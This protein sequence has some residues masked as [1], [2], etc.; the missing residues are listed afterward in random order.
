[1]VPNQKG[2]RVFMRKGC[3]GYLEA[4]YL[5]GTEGPGK[6]KGRTR[7]FPKRGADL[8]K[9]WREK[10]KERERDREKERERR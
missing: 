6:Y 5:V 9:W 1:M 3:L 7:G 4:F 2:R 10:E 8:M